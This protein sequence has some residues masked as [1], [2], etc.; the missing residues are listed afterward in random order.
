MSTITAQKVLPILGANLV[1]TFITLT[2]NSDSV[3]L[4]RMRSTSGQVVQLVRP[5]DSAA[6]V[7][8]TS[9]TAVTLTGTSGQSIMLISNHDD[10]IPNPVGDGA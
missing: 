4:P 5:G 1:A 10:P 8:Q 7:T 3:T 9:A 6:T 2:A